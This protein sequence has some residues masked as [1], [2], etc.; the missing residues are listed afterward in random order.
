MECEEKDFGPGAA[1]YRLTWG[2][3]R[4]DPRKGLLTWDTLGFKGYEQEESGDQCSLEGHLSASLA[5]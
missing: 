5:T 3:G 4:R 1:S 2:G